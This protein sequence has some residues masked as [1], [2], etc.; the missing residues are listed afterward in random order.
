MCQS[1]ELLQ[2][3]KW[4]SG[5]MPPR[6][7]WETIYY[8]ILR[9]QKFMT[10]SK[11][12]DPWIQHLLPKVLGTGK[13]NLKTRSHPVQCLLTTFPACPGGLGWNSEL[14][15][16]KHLLDAGTHI[17]STERV[18]VN[19][20]HIGTAYSLSQHHTAPL[21]YRKKAQAMRSEEAQGHRS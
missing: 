6:Y 1:A 2:D 21:G 3:H 14:S 19:S 12:V 16:V 11:S 17:L 20:Q 4:L 7:L 15:R 13:V 5:E 9:F 18:W 10:D 8:H